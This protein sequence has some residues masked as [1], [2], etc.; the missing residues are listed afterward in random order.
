MCDFTV[1][2]AISPRTA[3]FGGGISNLTAQRGIPSR[4][5]AVHGERRDF[6]LKFHGLP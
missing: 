6:S 2:F 5:L 1:E 3:P 4:N